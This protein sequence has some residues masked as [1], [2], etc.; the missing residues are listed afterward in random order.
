MEA[1]TFIIELIGIIALTL[2]LILIIVHFDRS[3]V[4]T[5]K[6]IVLKELIEH[7]YETDKI[8]LETY[9]K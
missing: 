1:F 7:G 9:I 3:E 2:A 6:T 5:I 8:D 4:R